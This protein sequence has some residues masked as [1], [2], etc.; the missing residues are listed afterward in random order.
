[1][2]A[3]VAIADYLKH[4]G[5]QHHLGTLRHA[6]AAQQ[7]SLL[8]A[9]A[10]HFPK[11][12]RLTRPRGGYFVWVELPES[13]DVLKLHRLALAQNISIAPGPMFSAQRK[14]HHCIRLN[15]GHP[16]SARMGGSR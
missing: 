6:L 14:F 13:V 1:M 9:V 12:M 2:P 8:Q 16:W 11:T 10:K 3:Q 7:N 4:G 15:Y 5:Y